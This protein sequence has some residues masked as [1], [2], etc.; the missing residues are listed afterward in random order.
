MDDDLAH[1]IV[2]FVRGDDVSLDIPT[3]KAAVHAFNIC[4]ARTDAG[5]KFLKSQAIGDA[6]RFLKSAGHEAAADALWSA[7]GQD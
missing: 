2:E 1:F 3:L 6:C 4:L 5:D 7:R